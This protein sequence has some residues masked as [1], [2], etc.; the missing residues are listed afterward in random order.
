[1][2][3]RRLKESKSLSVSCLARGVQVGDEV[4]VST[5]SYDAWETEKHQIAAVSTDGRVLTLNRPLNHAHIGQSKWSSMTCDP[6]PVTE[7]CGVV[8]LPMCLRWPALTSARLQVRLT[9]SRG[10]PPPTCWRPTSAS[11]PGTSRSSE[12][13]I[14]RWCRSRS[15]PDCWW[16]ATPGMESTTKVWGLYEWCVN[17]D[18]D[19]ASGFMAA[20]IFLFET[21]KLDLLLSFIRVW[22]N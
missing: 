1:M 12:R 16:A 3:V 19:D 7:S 2:D 22:I 13:S 6:L 18:Y 11:W 9:P 10:R 5:T 14:R 21:L 4:V 17:C 20:A 15:E 8:V